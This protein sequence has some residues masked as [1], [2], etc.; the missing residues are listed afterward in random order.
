[1]AL[2]RK[3][4][5]M[6]WDG[7]E[8]VAAW[9]P[10]GAPSFGDSLWNFRGGMATA[11]VAPTFHPATGWQFSGSEWLDTHVLP[12]SGY[13]I[14]VRYA[15]LTQTNDR[16]AVGAGNTTADG[17]EIRAMWN[18]SALKQAVFAHGVGWVAPASPGPAAVLA[19]AGQQ[20]YLNGV[21]WTSGG[22]ATLSSNAA[23][24]IGAKNTNAGTAR[25]FFFIGTISAVAVYNVTLAPAQVWQRSMMMAH[26]DNPDWNAWTRARQWW[27]VPYVPP[28]EP[29]VLRPAVT[30][31]M[32]RMRPAPVTGGS[33]GVRRL[34]AP[35]TGAKGR[36]Q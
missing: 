14:L 36:L 4:S 33:A 29:V 31:T 18:N 28:A 1:M 9:Q 32:G 34:N 35:V 11:T 25:Y 5:W 21:A 19:L 27:F 16:T 24:A 3:R 23:Y 2:Q 10:L 20:A 6:N 22:N 8:P 12:G 15:N 30:G 7:Y 26:L 17:H 13:T